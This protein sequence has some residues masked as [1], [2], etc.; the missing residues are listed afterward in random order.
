MTIETQQALQKQGFGLAGVAYV[1][2]ENLIDIADQFPQYAPVIEKTGIETVFR[3]DLS[4]VDLASS[5][6]N[7]L[8]KTLNCPAETI[9]CLI[10]VTQSQE[11]LLPSVSCMVQNTVGLSTSC[12]AFD[13][14]Q[15]CSGFAQAICVAV[16]MLQQFENVLIV[17]ADKYRNKLHR[18]DRSTETLFSDA[19]SA[20][21]VVRGE[22]F[23]LGSITSLTDGSGSTLLQQ[24]IG[25]DLSMSGA[26]VYVWTRSVV[27]KQIVQLLQHEAHLG[28]KSD[29]LL[30]HQAS[31]LVIDAIRS[32]VPTSV[33]I[34]TG[35]NRFGNTVSSSIPILLAECF[36]EVTARN[37]MIAGFG[38]GL[39]STAVA[40]RRASAK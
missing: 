3:S 1:L 14:N 9:Q 2:G 34:P 35:Y 11:F 31:K 36:A 24:P 15:G 38:V 33:T 18:G 29:Y 32:K 19:S 20:S 28:Y 16:S 25:D 8:L 21:L 37:F 13:I 26:D 27:A 10:V 39:S 5:A 4:I 23:H 22:D 7:K 17:C 30:L 40:V 6:A 12:M